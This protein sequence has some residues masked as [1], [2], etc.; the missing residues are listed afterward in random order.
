MM[1]GLLGVPRSSFYAR[2]GDAPRDPWAALRAEAERL[3]LGSGRRSGARTIHARLA[4][5]H[6]TIGYQVPAEK[7]DAFFKRMDEVLACEAAFPL[8]A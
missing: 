4:G 8:A 3:W 2:G 5:P 6:S 1:C 7:T